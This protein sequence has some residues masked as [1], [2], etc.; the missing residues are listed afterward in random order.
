M[1]FSRIIAVAAVAITAALAGSAKDFL[2]VNGPDIIDSKGEKFYIKG[3]NL[4]NCCC[5]EKILYKTVQIRN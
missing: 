5:P 4:G 1:R 2:K 3:T